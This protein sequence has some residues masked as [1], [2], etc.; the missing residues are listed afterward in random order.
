MSTGVV[1]SGDRLLKERDVLN[2]TGRKDE[3]IE[4]Y[5]RESGRS[6]ASPQTSSSSERLAIRETAYCNVHDDLQQLSE[7]ALGI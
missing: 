3:R 1:Q 4:Q 2:K 5:F 6:R 7:Y